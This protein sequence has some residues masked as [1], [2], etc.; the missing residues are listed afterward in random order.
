MDDIAEIAL[1]NETVYTRT[2]ASGENVNSFKIR[3]KNNIGLY[4]VEQ[5]QNT[6][7]FWTANKTINVTGKT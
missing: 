7:E 2:I 3:F 1:T 4:N 6:I 5:E